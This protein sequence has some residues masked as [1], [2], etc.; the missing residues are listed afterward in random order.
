MKNIRNSFAASGLVPFNPQRVLGQ[1]NIQLRTPT[2]PDSRST[3][4]APRTPHNLK[5]LGKQ[6]STI[7]RLLRQR[8][9]SPPSSISDA[10]NRLVK[11]CEIHMKNAILL[12]KEVQDLRAAHEKTLQKKKRSKRQIAHTDGLSIQEGIELL[13]QRNEV[14]RTEDTTQMETAP[15]TFQPHVREPPR[16]SDCNVLGHKRTHCPNRSSN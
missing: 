12:S 8:T 1:F 6:V 7:K 4:S 16:C 14:Q 10:I 2:P 5:H 15:S 9:Q 11:G 13:Q 3:N